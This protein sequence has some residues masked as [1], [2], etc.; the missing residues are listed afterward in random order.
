[1][2]MPREALE[3]MF[4]MLEYFQDDLD[5]RRTTGDEGLISDLIALEVDGRAL[6]EAELLGFCVLL[7]I[8]RTRDDDQDGVQRASR[9]CLGTPTN[10]TSSLPTL[11]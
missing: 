9:S 2:Q 7:V 11:T 1:M 6:T 4:E 5:R 10:V 3:G 8:R